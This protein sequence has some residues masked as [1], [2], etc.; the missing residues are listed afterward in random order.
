MVYHFSTSDVKNFHKIYSVTISAGIVF[1]SVSD[2]NRRK[3]YIPRRDDE[4]L[5]PPPRQVTIPESCRKAWGGRTHVNYSEIPPPYKYTVEMRYRAENHF[6]V[7]LYIPSKWYFYHRML[8]KIKFPLTGPNYDVSNYDYF[9][10]EF[11][12]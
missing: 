9:V 4:D 10:S 5:E 2:E 11:G 1:V 3:R 12:M 8:K 6:P 7:P